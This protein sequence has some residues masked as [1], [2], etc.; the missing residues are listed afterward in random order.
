M[1][2]ERFNKIAGGIQSLAVSL[3]ILT[4][5]VWTLYSF[6]SLHSIEKAKGDLERTRTEL[7]DILH[8]Q[9]VLDAAIT[10]RQA[11]RSPTGQYNIAVIVIM[12][13]KG[14]QDTKIQ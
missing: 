7:N 11:P 4:G 10:C 2:C 3:A 14:A 6:V 9:P 12:Q 5:G 13:N 1:D 8:R